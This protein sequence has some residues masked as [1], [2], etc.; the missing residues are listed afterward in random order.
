MSAFQMQLF[1]DGLPIVCLD[2]G[3]PISNRADIAE[4]CEASQ[5]M[6]GGHR[7]HF[8]QHAILVRREI[9]ICD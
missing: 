7:I 5:T 3:A 6:S 9:P 2:C 8:H 4:P 1:T